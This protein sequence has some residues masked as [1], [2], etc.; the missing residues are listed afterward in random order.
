LFI[1]YYTN[2]S[3]KLHQSAVS[4]TAEYLQQILEKIILL[5]IFQT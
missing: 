2:I 4:L 5:N 3:L 1:N